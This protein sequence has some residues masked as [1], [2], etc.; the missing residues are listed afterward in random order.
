MSD[1]KVLTGWQKPLTEVAVLVAEIAT[2]LG[3][4]DC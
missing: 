2:S 4:Q 3:H 1:A